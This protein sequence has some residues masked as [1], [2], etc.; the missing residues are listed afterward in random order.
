[1]KAMDRYLCGVHPVY[2]A[3]AAGKPPIERIH[4]AREIRSARLREILEMAQARGVPI[5]KEDRAALDRLAR[6]EVHQGI[7]AVAS[8]FEYSPAEKLFEPA[9]PCI[10]VLDGVEDPH[11]LGAIIRTAEA[12]S[13]SGVVVPE[14]HS[15][16]LGAAAAKA[17]A[18]ALAYVPVVRV[19]NLVNFLKHLKERNFW[20]VGVDADAERLWTEF[21]YKGAVALVLGAE[22]RGLRRLVREHCDALVKLPMA[23][24]IESLNVSV[25]AGVVLYEVL[26]QRRLGGT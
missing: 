14:R 5:R 21:D 1:M 24:K 20:V 12:C 2:G 15:A 17:A 18:G 25:A 4:I 8:E 3:L 9:A 11:N 26:R 23:G 19:G 6:G 16:P 7:V 13:V 22:H 10:V